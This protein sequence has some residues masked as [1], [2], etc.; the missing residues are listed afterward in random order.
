MADAAAN[1][2]LTLR[3]AE[4]DKIIMSGVASGSYEGKNVTFRSMEEL[5][6]IRDSIVRQ[7][8]IKPA[9]RR[10]VVGYSGGF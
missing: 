7:M 3:L 6:T 8:G 5:S 10:T 4:L 9:V 1:L 2:L